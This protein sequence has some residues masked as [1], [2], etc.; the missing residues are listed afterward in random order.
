MSEIEVTPEIFVADYVGQPG[1]RVFF[2]QATSSGETFTFGLEK[3]QV[4]LLAEKLSE[5]LLMIDSEDTI[6]GTEP[7]R[8]PALAVAQP[9]EPAWRVGT[10]ALAYEEHEDQ[11]VV[12][13]EPLQPQ[14]E[15][16]T[17][18]NDETPGVRF[19]LRRDQVRAF[20]LHAVAAAEEGRPL[21]QLCGL[22]MDPEGHAC[23]ASNGHR[24]RV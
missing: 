14:E 8:D 9:V 4:Q 22:P 23:P 11:V 2:L 12:V 15:Q 19:L 1:H 21:C 13:V 24:P 18:E 10:I 20:I 6:T 7:Q 3:Q 5:L 16:E 17:V